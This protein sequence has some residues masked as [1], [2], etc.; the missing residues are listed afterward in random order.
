MTKKPTVSAIMLKRYR[1][2]KKFENAKSVYVN[3]AL[4]LYDTSVQD[5][6]EGSSGSTLVHFANDTWGKFGDKLLEILIKDN[7]VKR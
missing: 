5:T 7:E 6:K 4:N 2:K 3:R 1:K